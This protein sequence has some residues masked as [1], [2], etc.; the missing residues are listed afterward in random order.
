MRLD[1]KIVYVLLWNVWGNVTQDIFGKF[2]IKF[3]P[4]CFYEIF[5]KISKI[6]IWNLWQNI[7]FHNTSMK[8][9]TKNYPRYF[10]HIFYKISSKIFLWYLWQNIIRDTAM[11]YLFNIIQ[12]ISLTKIIL[13]ISMKFLRKHYSRYVYEIID[14]IWSKII[15]RP[16]RWFFVLHSSIFMERSNHHEKEPDLKWMLEATNCTSLI[17]STIAR[18]RSLTTKYEYCGSRQV[19]FSW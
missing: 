12:E 4:R 7:I 18:Q 6:F 14:I 3:Y 5:D 10:Y 19:L 8:S 1:N 16:S 2:M 11:I 15:Q 9:W 13:D 17:H